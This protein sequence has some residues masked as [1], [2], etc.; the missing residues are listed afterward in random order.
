MIEHDEPNNQV[1][2]GG[3]HLIMDMST[4]L[5]TRP[6]LD[7]DEAFAERALQPK[8]SVMASAMR[9]AWAPPCSCVWVL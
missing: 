3:D 5:Y 1:N 4:P 8:D 9:P 6:F 2:V 7:R